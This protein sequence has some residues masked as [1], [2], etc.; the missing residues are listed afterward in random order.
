MSRIRGG[1]VTSARRAFAMPARSS[2]RKASR[3]LVLW[4]EPLATMACPSDPAD[5]SL[6]SGHVLERGWGGMKV[7][8]RGKDTGAE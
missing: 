4:S 5:G 8:A 3:V 7:C 6:C 1:A 2:L